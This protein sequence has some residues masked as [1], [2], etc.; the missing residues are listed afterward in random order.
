MGADADGAAGVGEVGPRRVPRLREHKGGGD[1]PGEQTPHAQGAVRELRR[2]FRKLRPGSQA[3][4]PH[5]CRS[6]RLTRV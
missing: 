5:D 3:V 6:R 2:I 4:Q 1:V